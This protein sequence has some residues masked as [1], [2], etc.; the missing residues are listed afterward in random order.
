[1]EQSRQVRRIYAVKRPG[2]DVEA[3]SVLHNLRDNLGISGLAGIRVYNRYDLSGVT[4][5][6]YQAARTIVF[7]EPPVDD[8]FDETVSFPDGAFVFAVESL[9]GQYDQR[10]D[11]AAQC[12]QFLTGGQRPSCLT[13]RVYCLTGD[14][15]L[16][17]QDRIRSYLINPVE[18]REA[19]LEKPA[20]LEQTMDSPPDI[21]VLTGFRSMGDG[22]LAEMRAGLGLAMTLEDLKFCQAYFAGEKRDPTL[23]EIRVLDTYWSD[24]CRHTT[25]LTRLDDI[26]FEGDP[27][28]AGHMRAVFDRYLAA[29]RRLYGDRAETRP[30]CLMDLATIAMKELRAAGRLPRLDI[31]EEDRKSVV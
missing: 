28:F 30:V 19:S 11:S 6:E 1:M 14:I 16:E 22:A 15:S 18:C 9:P 12:V 27:A 5:E 8:V 20:S 2:F 25:F 17:E 29:R 10:A 7:S 31:S 4:E 13:A 24:H 3:Q 23:T 26:R 21:P